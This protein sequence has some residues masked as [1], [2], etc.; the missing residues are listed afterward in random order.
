MSRVFSR[1]LQARR[2][3]ACYIQRAERETFAAKNILSS[4]AI[5]QSRR[6][7]EFLRQKVRVHEH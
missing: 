2:E 1:K 4:K 6:E 7:K 5:I 3:V